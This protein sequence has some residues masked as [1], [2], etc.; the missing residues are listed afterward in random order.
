M[1][2]AM[3]AHPIRVS[4]H[5]RGGCAMLAG[6]FMTGVLALSSGMAMGVLL[7]RAGGGT[8]I[9][10]I[11]I[12]HYLLHLR[13]SILFGTSAAVTTVNAVMLYGVRRRV[14]QGALK[15]AIWFTLPGLLGMILSRGIPHTVSTPFRLALLGLL[16][17]VNTSISL[18]LPKNVGLPPVVHLKRLALVGCAIG[19]IVGYFGGAGGFLAFPTMLISGLPQSLAVGSSTLTVAGFS[20]TAA[21]RDILR[22]DVNWMVVLPYIAGASVGLFAAV[23]WVRLRIPA[24]M[25]HW[26]A[27]ILILAAGLF[28]LQQNWGSLYRPSIAIYDGIK[29]GLLHEFRD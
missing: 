8:L 21:V 16:M 7:A 6:E 18:I 20:L 5:E 1:I 25:W 23:Y 14:L 22:A 19:I 12:L 28:L 26:T 3:P 29:G 10:S 17:V 9:L 24:K 11:I 4:H 15:P 27:T 2:G 13:H